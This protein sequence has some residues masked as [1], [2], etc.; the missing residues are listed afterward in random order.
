MIKLSSFYNK[1]VVLCAQSNKS[2]S[3]VTEAIGLSR[4]SPNGWKKGKQPNDLTLQKL[5]NYFGVSVAYLKGEEESVDIN[6]FTI[7]PRERKVLEL[8]KALT[9]DE[10]KQVSDYIDFV[11]SKSVKYN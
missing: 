3:S 5:A 10:V 6:G 7:T 2:L 4:T 8:I 11:I 9:D 1:F